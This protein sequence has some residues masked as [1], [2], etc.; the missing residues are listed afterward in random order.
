[1]FHIGRRT[2]LRIAQV[3]RMFF[4]SEVRWRARLLFGGL[5]A[6][7]LGVNGLNVLSSYIGRDVMTALADRRAGDF[8]PAA[9]RYL[10]VFALLT[11]AVSVQRFCEE[12]LGLLWRTWLTR[13]LLNLYLRDRAYLRIR[14]LPGVDNADERI[15]EDVKAFTANALSFTILGMNGLMTTVAFAGVAWAISPALLGACVLYAAAGSAGAALLGRRLPGLN[16]HQLDREAEFRSSLIHVRENAP[17]IA[18]TRAEAPLRDRLIARFAGLAENLRGIIRLNL[19]LNLFTNG[20]NYLIPVV[21]VLVVGPLYLDGRVEFGVVTQSAVVFAQ[22]VGAFALLVTQYQAYSSF[23]AVVARLEALAGAVTAPPDPKGVGVEVAAAPD[24]VAFG[25]LTLRSSDGRAVLVDDLTAAVGPGERVVVTGPVGDA[26]VAL[27]LAT[28]GMWPDGHGRVE[29]PAGSATQFVTETPYLAPG[30]LRDQFRSADPGGA[31]DDVRVRSALA[32][33]G[34]ADLPDRAGGLDA[35][36]DWAGHLPLEDRQR[37]ALARVLFAR[38][39]FA[40]LDRVGTALGP[41]AGGLL[42]RLTAAGIGWVA[43]VD[44]EAPPARPDRALHLAPGGG[45]TV[46]PTPARD[47]L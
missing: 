12:R 16:S 10:G 8:W 3:V 30:T 1:M 15:A 5:V 45:W 37:L 31:A 41:A 36:G 28:A 44:G 23:A 34:L 35:A 20:F 11:A 26:R 32:A 38:P 27:F 25:G 13:R 42:D 18:L 6:L 40:V 9:G 4:T 39:R 47:D 43:F 24:R 14:D 29:R 7:L 19:N 22:L 17:M 46:T 2:W 21:P 33:V